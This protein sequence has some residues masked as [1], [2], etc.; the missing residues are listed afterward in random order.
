MCACVCA[1]LCSIAISRTG[2]HSGF[3][4]SGF[5]RPCCRNVILSYLIVARISH[6]QQASQP[7]ISRQPG[8][9]EDSSAVTTLA[10]RPTSLGRASETH[11]SN[12]SSELCVLQDQPPRHRS[13]E[14]HGGVV[15]GPAR[16][17][18]LRRGPGLWTECGCPNRATRPGPSTSSS[19]IIAAG[20]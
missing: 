2:L 5:L 13:S 18:S 14:G 4:R 3:P 15:G 9:S 7:A 1:S 10:N 20:H 8:N 19:L 12:Q 16:P 6:G 17:F 11:T